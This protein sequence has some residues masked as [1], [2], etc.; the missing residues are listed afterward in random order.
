M[1]WADAAVLAN[2]VVR[3]ARVASMARRPDIDWKVVEDEY[4]WGE[5]IKQDREGNFSRAYPTLAQLGKKYGCSMALVGQHAKKGNWAKRRVYC[6]KK[7]KEEVQK[8]LDD[9]HAKARASHLCDALGAIEHWIG[10]FRQA[11]EDEHFRPSTNMSDLNTAVRLRAFL[12]GEADHRAEQ[13]VVHSIEE[14]TRRHL[15]LRGRGGAHGASTSG[16]L[17]TTGEPVDEDGA[18]SSNSRPLLEAGVDELEGGEP[19]ADSDQKRPAAQR[20]PGSTT[21]KLNRPGARRAGN[22]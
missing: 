6:E 1:R 16:I 21:R 8:E 10:K 3:R 2:E 9:Q 5:E 20:K 11:V 18:A 14:L 13:K 22:Q 12:K 7:T 15:E 19:L 17:E 4:V